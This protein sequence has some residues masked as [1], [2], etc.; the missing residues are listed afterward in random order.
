MPEESY[1]YGCDR[2][3][4]AMD[5]NVSSRRTTKAGPT[6]TRRRCAR[7]PAASSVLSL[8]TSTLQND[9]LPGRR[10]RRADPYS[11]SI[12]TLKRSARSLSR[13][14]PAWPGRGARKR[15][16]TPLTGRTTPRERRLSPRPSPRVRASPI[17]PAPGSSAPCVAETANAAE[18]RVA[19]GVRMNIALSSTRTPIRVTSSTGARN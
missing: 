12:V 1:Y 7:T 17:S 3:A 9:G 4:P 15:N 10:T 6:S 16:Y 18:A 2:V 14:A 11:R 8:P 19:V 5:P 13:N